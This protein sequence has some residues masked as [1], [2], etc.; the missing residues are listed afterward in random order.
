[1]SA[2]SQ[3]IQKSDQRRP[4]IQPQEEKESNSRAP[5][6][7]LEGIAPEA[8]L[9]L[10]GAAS[11][12]LRQA[13]VI[14]MQAMHGNSV[15][16][17]NLEERDIGAAPVT[18]PSRLEGPAGSISVSGGLAEINAPA[19]AL[20]A[21]TVSLNGMLVGGSLMPNQVL[22][23]GSVAGETLASMGGGIKSEGDMQAVG[24]VFSTGN[25]T[26]LGHVSGLLGVSTVGDAKS[27]RV[28][29]TDIPG[30]QKERE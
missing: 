18:P 5:A 24:N 9:Q 10:P 27:L 14:Q 30:W 1:M 2:Q 29:T 21:P 3:R 15:V 11:Q 4:H 20:K 16:A 8:A 13:A 7:A 22:A 26:S 6:Q 28:I 25:V 17:R 23:T 12:S 19:I